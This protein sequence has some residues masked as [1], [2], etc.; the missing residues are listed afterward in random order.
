MQKVTGKYFALSQVIILFTVLRVTLITA[1]I[2][3]M[4]YVCFLGCDYSV[5]MADD[6]LSA[7]CKEEHSWRAIPCPHDYCKY[8]AF[9]DTSHKACCSYVQLIKIL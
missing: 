1:K 7:H 4:F 3:K 5:K 9:S 2:S 8:E 6:C